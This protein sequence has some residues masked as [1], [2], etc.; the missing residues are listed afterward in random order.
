MPFSKEIV[1]GFF[2]CLGNVLPPKEITWDGG[3]CPIFHCQYRR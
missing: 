2:K 3:F 1:E